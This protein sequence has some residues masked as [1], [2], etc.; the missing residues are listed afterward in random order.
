MQNGQTQ[1]YVAFPG[2]QF[3]VES[4]RFAY[5]HLIGMGVPRTRKLTIESVPKVGDE[6]CDG[7]AF[8]EVVP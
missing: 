2:H 5:D 3:D 1:C 7:I 8:V 4:L 6:K